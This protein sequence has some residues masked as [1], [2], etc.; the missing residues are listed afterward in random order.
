MINRQEKKNYQKKQ[1]IN[2]REKHR[3]KKQPDN[4]QAN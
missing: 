1:Q 2:Q 3:E 4:N